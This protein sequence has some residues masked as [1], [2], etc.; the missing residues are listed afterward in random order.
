VNFDAKAA[1]NFADFLDGVLVFELLGFTVQIASAATVKDNRNIKAM[2][3]KIFLNLQP[4]GFVNL[5]LVRL[6]C[7]SGSYDY[8][9]LSFAQSKNRVVSRPELL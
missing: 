5:F 9:K 1:R 4:A 6:L 8:I 7:A 2:L 3:E